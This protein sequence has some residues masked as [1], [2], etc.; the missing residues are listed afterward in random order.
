MINMMKVVNIFSGKELGTV[1]GLTFYNNNGA[2][3]TFMNEW[4]M[5]NYLNSYGLTIKQSILSINI[6]KLINLIKIGI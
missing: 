3:K 2:T 5:K 1:K 4:M 6:K